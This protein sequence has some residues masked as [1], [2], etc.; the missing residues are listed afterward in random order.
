MRNL[1][2]FSGRFFVDLSVSLP[3]FW[4]Q[5]GLVIVGVS[6]PTFSTQGR[7]FSSLVSDAEDFQKCEFSSEK[8]YAAV[9]QVPQSFL[10]TQESLDMD[11]Q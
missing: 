2:C 8:R 11:R 3:C 1:V 10:K 9:E 6:N 4:Q 7:D 5:S